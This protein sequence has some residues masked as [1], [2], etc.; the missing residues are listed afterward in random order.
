MGSCDPITSRNHFDRFCVPEAM[1]QKSLVPG[2]P[3][4]N[5]AE[6]VNR[7]HYPVRN[8][9]DLERNQAA[10]ARAAADAALR[11]VLLVIAQ[12]PRT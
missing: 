8:A 12:F 11:K 1:V 10:V 6:T 7:V 9:K 4:R 3:E 5:A 2:L